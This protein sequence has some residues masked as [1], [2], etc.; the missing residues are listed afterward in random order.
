VTFALLKIAVKAYQELSQIA[1]AGRGFISHSGPGLQFVV[2][3]CLAC[4]VSTGG[5][6]IHHS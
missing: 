6:G 2:K 5:Y 4:I 1:R 3:Y